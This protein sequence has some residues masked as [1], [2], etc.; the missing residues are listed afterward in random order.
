MWILA[1]AHLILLIIAS[2]DGFLMVKESEHLSVYIG[3]YF[4]PTLVEI[5]SLGYTGQERRKQMK[6]RTLFEAIKS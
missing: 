4:A 5:H 3:L 1:S 2:L 6:L